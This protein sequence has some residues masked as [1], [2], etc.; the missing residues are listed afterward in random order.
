[1]KKCFAPRH[2]RENQLKKSQPYCK[3][4]L[5]R[6]TGAKTIP[7]KSISQYSIFSSADK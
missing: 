6:A 7:L 4:A 3:S 1:M 2:K 5:S